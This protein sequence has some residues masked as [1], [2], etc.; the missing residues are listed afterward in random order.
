ML[1]KNSLFEEN[2][3]QSALDVFLWQ[4]HVSIGVSIM[5]RCLLQ[6]H[7]LVKTVHIATKPE[8]YIFPSSNPPVYVLHC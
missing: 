7:L 2:L 8:K 6:K 4:V 3:L 1:K 5:A